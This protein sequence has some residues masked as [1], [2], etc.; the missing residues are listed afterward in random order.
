[1][2]IRLDFTFLLFGVFHYCYTNTKLCYMRNGIA[3]NNTKNVA[4]T[5]KT[6]E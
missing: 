4:S 3:K 2:S 5:V 1:M 6:R